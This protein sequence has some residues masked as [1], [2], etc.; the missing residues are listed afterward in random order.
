M[1]KLNRVIQNNQKPFI[2]KFVFAL[3]VAYGLNTQNCEPGQRVL[4]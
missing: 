4:S 1:V 2:L 3:E